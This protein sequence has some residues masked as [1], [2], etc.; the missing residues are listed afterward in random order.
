MDL[1]TASKMI[2]TAINVLKEQRSSNHF[3]NL[4]TKA[5]A[6]AEKEDVSTDFEIIRMRKPK[7][8]AGEKARDERVTD[9]KVR[10]RSSVSY[11]IYDTLIE[12][13]SIPKLGFIWKKKWKGS[14]LN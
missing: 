2:D 1:V 13:L 5:R 8:M 7:Q 10:F 4:L 11:D 6:I 14:D 12:E 3:D 9:P